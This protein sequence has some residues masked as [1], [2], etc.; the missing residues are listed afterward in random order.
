[1]PCSR[2]S[3]L[4]VESDSALPVTSDTDRSPSR[5][6]AYLC[7]VA[8]HC[9]ACFGCRVLRVAPAGA[10]D[11]MHPRRRFGEGRHVRP[12][13][14]RQRVTTGPRE[15]AILE[16]LVTH[17]GEGDERVAAQ[18]KLAALP[19]DHE[20]LDPAP[21]AVRCDDEPETVTARAV[22]VAAGFG[23]GCDE[24][25]G[26]CSLSSVCHDLLPPRLPPCEAGMYRNTS[27]RSSTKYAEIAVFTR[28]CKNPPEHLWSTP[29]RT[30]PHFRLVLRIGKDPGL[31]T[32]S[33]MKEDGAP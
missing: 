1:M 19:E 2:S 20:S 6:K 14:E 13:L 5:G 18:A 3:L 33:R 29:M 4:K 31:R 28:G 15:L 26:Q 16:R 25:R 30:L 27:D 12:P 17:F 24:A 22:A 32:P 23:D 9:A 21:R 10:V 11:I 7:K 8:I